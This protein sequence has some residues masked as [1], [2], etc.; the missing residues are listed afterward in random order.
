M[1]Y[2]EK[3]LRLKDISPKDILQILF[4]K[5]FI[6][7]LLVYLLFVLFSFHISDDHTRNVF[8]YIK[9]IKVKK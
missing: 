2:F 7:S 8:C 4:L 1:L 3:K 5:T 6:P 9:K